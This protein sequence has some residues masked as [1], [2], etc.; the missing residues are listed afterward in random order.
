M[1]CIIFIGECKLENMRTLCVACHSNVTAAQRAERCS[2]MEKARKQLEVIM[3]DIKCMEEETSTYV[4]VN[5]ECLGLFFI[6]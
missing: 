5:L 3:N 6:S 4:K 1:L 2:T